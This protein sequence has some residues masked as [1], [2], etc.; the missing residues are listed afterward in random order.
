MTRTTP[1]KESKRVEV[2]APRITPDRLTR[3]LAANIARAGTREPE[4]LARLKAAAERLQQA[5]RQYP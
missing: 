2:K 5:R 3:V 1:K 4:L